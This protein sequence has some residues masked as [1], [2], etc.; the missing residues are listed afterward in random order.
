MEQVFDE[1]DQ[2]IDFLVGSVRDRER[3]MERNKKQD[4]GTLPYINPKK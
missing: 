3:R 4:R 1:T 2:G